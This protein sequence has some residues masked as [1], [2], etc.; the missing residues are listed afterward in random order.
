MFSFL[1]NSNS[2]VKT[3]VARGLGYTENAFAFLVD[4]GVEGDDCLAGAAIADDEFPLASSDRDQRLVPAHD[5]SSP[6]GS[7]DRTGGA[8]RCAITSTASRSDRRF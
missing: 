5:P 2:T 6:D 8:R 3:S 1:S 4:D 7:A